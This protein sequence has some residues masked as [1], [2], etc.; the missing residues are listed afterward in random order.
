LGSC[1]VAGD[2]KPY[3][4]AVADLLGAPPDQK[5]VSLV[6]VGYAVSVPSPTKRTLGELLHW[7]KF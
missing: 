1:W 4:G 5:L 7:E 3:S 2:R 6:A